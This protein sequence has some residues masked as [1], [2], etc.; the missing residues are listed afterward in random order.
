MPAFPLCVQYNWLVTRATTEKMQAFTAAMRVTTYR[1]TEK[2]FKGNWE[3][4]SCLGI[5]D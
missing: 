3:Q 4:Y 2:V 5:G 1:F